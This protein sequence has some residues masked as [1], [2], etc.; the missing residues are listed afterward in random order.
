[1][2][3]SHRGGCIPRT[4]DPH[5][6]CSEGK[7]HPRRATREG[8][9]SFVPHRSQPRRR[10]LKIHKTERAD[11]ILAFMGENVYNRTIITHFS[12]NARGFS[13]KVIIVGRIFLFCS[14]LTRTEKYGKMIL[15]TESRRTHTDRFRVRLSAFKQNKMVIEVST[16]NPSMGYPCAFWFLLN[17]SRKEKIK[18]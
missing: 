8:E 3:L 16:R 15:E 9:L 10:S 11:F 4:R 12:K 7:C 13:K 5:T 14:P 17:V 2:L 18:Q 6:A 1:M